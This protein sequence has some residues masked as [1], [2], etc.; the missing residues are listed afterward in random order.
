[1]A[2][3]AGRPYLSAALGVAAARAAKSWAGVSAGACT[4]NSRGHNAVMTRTGVWAE[5]PAAATLLLCVRL[6][7]G[8][9]QCNGRAGDGCERDGGFAGD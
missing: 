2:A 9:Q 6:A 5:Q 8:L 4:S 1:M 3:A 7:R